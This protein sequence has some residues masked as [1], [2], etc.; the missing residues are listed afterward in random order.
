MHL[1]LDLRCIARTDCTP[2][3]SFPARPRS[4]RT[5]L[6]HQAGDCPPLRRTLEQVL[7][8]DYTITH[9]TLQVDHSV[10]ATAAHAADG[11]APPLNSIVSRL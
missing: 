2:N 5:W 7:A 8:E 6:V 4:R 10:P 9:A 3:R 11:T 1:G